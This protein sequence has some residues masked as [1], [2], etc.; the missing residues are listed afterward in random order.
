M[1]TDDQYSFTKILTRNEIMSYDALVALYRPV[2]V[3][4]AKSVFTKEEDAITV[5][6]PPFGILFCGNTVHSG[7]GW[8]EETRE[9]PRIHF[10]IDPPERKHDSKSQSF[11]NVTAMKLFETLTGFNYFINFNR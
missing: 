9:S 2:Y 8:T 5:K 6:I 11:V 10:Y 3:R 1:H 4:V 7:T